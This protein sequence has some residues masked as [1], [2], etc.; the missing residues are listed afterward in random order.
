MPIPQKVLEAVCL[1]L[2]RFK[3]TC[4]HFGV[5]DENIYLL[6]TEATR[7]AP[8]SEDFR[9]AVLQAT[10]WTVTLLAKEE[11]GR[12][13]AIGAAAG[14]PS[15]NGLVMDLG[16]GST[17]LTW[18]LHNNGE[19]RLSDKGA[20]SLP[21]GAAALMQRL[22]KA[23]EPG[24]P[25][26]AALKREV[27]IK[28]ENALIE[29]N[30]PPELK[31]KS[32]SLYVTGG[33]FRGWG[34]VLMQRHSNSPYPIP[35]INGF[36]VK[37]NAV[38][39]VVKSGFGVSKRRVSQMPAIDFLV[40]AMGDAFAIEDVRFCQGGVRE[41]FLMT[42]LS[43]EII[44]VPP[45]L[46]FSAQFKPKSS[47]RLLQLL[48]GVIPT[49]KSGEYF[50]KLS[51][52]SF[53]RLF[54]APGDVL[55]ETLVNLMYYFSPAQKELRAPM[56][57]HCMITGEFTSVFPLSHD[58]RAMLA[59]AFFERWQGADE[60]RPA[61]VSILQRL[62]AIL[63]K[64]QVW[65]LKYIGRVAALLGNVYPAGFVPD[66]DDLDFNVALPPYESTAGGR[67]VVE[68]KVVLTARSSNA[69]IQASLKSGLKEIQGLSHSDLMY[70]SILI[71]QSVGDK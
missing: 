59:I 26:R 11:E 58:D 37:T 23:D 52:E 42:K 7:T 68:V 21:Y 50:S 64:R 16:G 28:I 66:D 25:G 36:R 32:I 29:L 1:A 35:A 3:T 43:S 44:A 65:W 39:A 27:T 22:Q 40:S 5:R 70:P 10:G 67:P 47:R 19:F 41:G 4:S 24:S 8:N 6:A 15:A 57:L 45:L 63:D 61:E 71:E 2:R 31:K 33:G 48:R 38:P 12:L 18:I 51:E 9:R 13:G 17:Q 30:I 14:F 69:L 60:V 53:D 55:L 49:E 34:Y 54:G 46:V 56:A 62:Q 20:V